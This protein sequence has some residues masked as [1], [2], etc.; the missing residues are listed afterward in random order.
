MPVSHRRIALILLIHQYGKQWSLFLKHAQG[1]CSAI[2]SSTLCIAL[3][4]FIR[5]SAKVQKNA[6]SCFL[7]FTAIRENGERFVHTR[8]KHCFGLTFHILRQMEKARLFMMEM[9]QSIRIT[10]RVPFTM[11]GRKKYRSLENRICVFS[12]S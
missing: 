8:R 4:R 7:K 10:S 11:P 12:R 9:E 2:L 1:Y 3:H 6:E 5:S